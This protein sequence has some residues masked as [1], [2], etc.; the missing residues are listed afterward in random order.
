MTKSDELKPCPFCGE[1]GSLFASGDHSGAWEGGCS[2]EGCVA[3]DLVWDTS[4]ELAIAA[5]NRRA[6]PPPERDDVLAAARRMLGPIEADGSYA[7]DGFF[8]DATLVARALLSSAEDVRR[9]RDKII[10]VMARAGASFEE[11]EYDKFPELFIEQAEYMLAALAKSG[12]AVV[13]A[14]DVR[15]MREAQVETRCK[16][17]P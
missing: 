7:V 9:E 2:S 4:K 11:V 5:W 12:M 16:F 6:S 13:A 8:T 3:N 10:K 15:R 1:P 14:E 17:Q